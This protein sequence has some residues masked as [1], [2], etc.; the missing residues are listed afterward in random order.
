M[1]GEKPLFVVALLALKA[2]AWVEGED[3]PTDGRFRLMRTD[4][5]ES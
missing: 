1:S 3:R 5:T 4:R 2:K